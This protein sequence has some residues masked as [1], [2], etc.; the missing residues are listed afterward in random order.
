MSVKPEQ[1]T[2]LAGEECRNA[3]EYA[4]QRVEEEA[5]EILK[6][7]DLAE[8][9]QC[10]QGHMQ[11]VLRELAKDSE[12]K[13]VGWGRYAAIPGDEP[14]EESGEEVSEAEEKE[15]GVPSVGGGVRSQGTDT[16]EERRE[17]EPIQCPED[18]CEY[19]GFS[20]EGL[21]KHSNA[22]RSHDWKDIKD[23]IGVKELNDF[24]RSEDL[25]EESMV[26]EE[27]LQMQRPATTGEDEEEASG[28][29]HGDDP[30]DDQ[31]EDLDVEQEA[32][33]V[34][35]YIE[36]DGK[37]IPLPVSSTVLIVAVAVGIAA[38]WLFTRYSSG[39]TQNQQE[40]QEQQEDVFSDARG[41]I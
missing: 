2:E 36:K 16:R 8:E 7:E 37:G 32:A 41:L 22:V 18:G 14:D 3:R 25:H 20:V 13:R 10:T 34:E 15:V 19:E 24:E 11:T 5:G 12:I 27:E 35:K 29:G 40:Q 21:R 33:S 38:L 6:S 4:L 28:G 9:Y 39:G 17:N 30:G 1:Q 23:E 26:T 31:A